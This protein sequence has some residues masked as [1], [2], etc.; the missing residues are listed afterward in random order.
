MPMTLKDKALIHVLV[1]ALFIDNFVVPLDTIQPDLK[2]DAMKMKK[3]SRALGLKT[4]SKH[5]ERFLA[6]R[7]PLNFEMKSRSYKRRTR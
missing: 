5:D 7:L 6:L 3:L 4:E 2:M 1:L